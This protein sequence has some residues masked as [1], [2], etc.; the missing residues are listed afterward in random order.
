VVL[1]EPRLKQ[2]V[3]V[4]DLRLFRITKRALNRWDIHCLCGWHGTR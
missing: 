2:K 4:N 1:S 3:P